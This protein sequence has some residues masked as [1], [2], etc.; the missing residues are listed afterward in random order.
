MIQ[1][2]RTSG[3][4]IDTESCLSAARAVRHC[5]PT[6]SERSDARQMPVSA[7]IDLPRNFANT[8]VRD[9]RARFVLGR[10]VIAE[11]QV[12]ALP[13]IEHLNVNVFEDVLDRFAPR[14]GPPLI[15]QLAL[16]CSEEALHTSVIPAVP[17]AAHLGMRPSSSSRR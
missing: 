6:T 8:G 7:V 14:H 13:I 12:A 1:I 10:G 5:V 3:K 2:H 16:Q 9:S 15:H 17:F 4:V 11:G